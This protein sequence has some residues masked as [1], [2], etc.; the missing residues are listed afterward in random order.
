MT[1]IFI[2]LIIFSALV[3]KWWVDKQNNKKEIVQNQQHLKTLTTILL[4]KNRLLAKYEKEQ[5]G[6]ATKQVGPTEEDMVES[7]LY[8]RNILTDADWASFKIYFENAHPGLLNRLRS[9]FSS[10]TD[11]EERLFL[12]IKLNLTTKEIASILGIAPSSVKKTRNR[13][14]KRLE[15]EEDTHL[16]EFVK[17]F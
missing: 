3:W 1:F 16:E 17:T 12:L 10:L 5:A 13:L 11:A 14:R 4:E 8:S 7:N 9:A 6:M 2:G 15:I